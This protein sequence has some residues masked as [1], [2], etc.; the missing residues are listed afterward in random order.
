[1]KQKHKKS[2][3]ELLASLRGQQADNISITFQE[4]QQQV[5]GD[6]QDDQLDNENTITPTLSGNNL[7]SSSSSNE[8]NT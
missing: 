8:A 7:N 4:L 6:Q 3:Q 1:M 2:V 5:N